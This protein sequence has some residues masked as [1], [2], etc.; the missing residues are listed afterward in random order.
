M[1]VLDLWA[2]LLAITVLTLTPGVD[3]LLVLR[4]ATR[5]GVADGVTTSLGICCGLFIH[6]GISALGISLILMQTL[7]A[8]TL[9]KALGAA[10]L[11]WLGVMSLSHCR[12]GQALVIRAG[13]GYA[14][15]SLRMGRSFREGLLSNLL[16]PKTA[17]FYLAFLPQFIDPEAAALPQALFLAGLHFILAMLWQSLLAVMVSRARDWLARP[18]VGQLFH[19]L[20]G[21]ILIAIGARLAVAP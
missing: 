8:F 20:T 19:G 17:L 10:Y 16:N 1:P 6:A 9:L 3:T 21:G 5:G 13:V 11:I 2:Y 14:H 4:N 15:N 18:R 7:W 12:R